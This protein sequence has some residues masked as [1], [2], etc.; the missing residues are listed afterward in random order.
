M[1][2]CALDSR[3]II[4]HAK[5]V[6][7]GV[8]GGEI[9][10]DRKN[11]KKVAYLNFGSAKLTIQNTEQAYATAEFVLALGYETVV[12]MIPNRDLSKEKYGMAD[13]YGDNVQNVVFRAAAGPRPH[14]I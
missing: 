3:G 8:I 1:T 13:R 5:L 4:T 14:D 7:R 9:W 10:F 12:A 2:P 6:D 11:P